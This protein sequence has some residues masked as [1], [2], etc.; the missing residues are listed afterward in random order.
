MINLKLVYLREVAPP[1]FT[2]DHSLKKNQSH[3]G[4]MNKIVNLHSSHLKVS[5]ALYYL[6]QGNKNAGELLN[7][8][9]LTLREMEQIKLKLT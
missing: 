6:S 5:E 7:A 4:G 9:R 3:D 8:L 2:F 1:C